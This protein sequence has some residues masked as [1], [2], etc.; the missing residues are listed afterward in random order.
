MVV[1]KL[2]HDESIDSC[3][4]KTFS[5]TLPLHD[6]ALESMRCEIIEQ[7]IK[8]RYPPPDQ[9]EIIGLLARGSL[10]N[11]K[12]TNLSILIENQEYPQRT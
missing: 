7:S 2:A 12:V 4:L 1:G 8:G 10:K 6:E 11:G 3:Y 9:Q 5:G